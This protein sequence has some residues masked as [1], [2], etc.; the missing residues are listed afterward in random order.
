MEVSYKCDDFNIRLVGKIDRIDNRSG[1]I[2]VID[3]KTGTSASL[4][5]IED[6]HFADREA[7]PDKIKSVQLPFYILL[8]MLSNPGADINSMEASLMMLGK[9]KGG[10][11]DQL[12]RRVVRRKEIILDKREY[13]RK[14]KAVIDALIADIFNLDIP[15]VPTSDQK[16][17]ARCDFKL[18][19]GRQWAV[20]PAR[21]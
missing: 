9:L 7:W 11:E 3:Y 21:P 14:C 12:F 10:M 16:K 18:F 1:K 19:C 13:F 17:C 15:F 8:Y 2:W 20:E 5:S 4:P 6:Y